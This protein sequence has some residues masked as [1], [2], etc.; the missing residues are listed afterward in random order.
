MIVKDCG[1]PLHPLAVGVMVIVA[2]T[3]V[4]PVFVAVND[5]ILLP[6]PDAARPIDVVLFVQVYVVPLTGPEKEIVVV[7][8]A[9]QKV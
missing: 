1:V 5:P 3:M 8:L 4:V 2:V 7:L 6:L 9:L